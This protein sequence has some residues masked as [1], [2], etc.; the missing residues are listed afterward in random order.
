[1]MRWRILALLFF[2][3]IGLGFQFQTLASV[4]DG[5]VLAFGLDYAGVGLLVGL[6][7]A[8]GLFLALPA[9]YLGRLIADRE[10]V[11][12]GLVAYW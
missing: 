1:M 6:F 12:L 4:G 5:L 3:R 7:M 2:A 11:V 9:G 8:P 10:M